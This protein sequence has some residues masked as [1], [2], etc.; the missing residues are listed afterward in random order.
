MLQRHCT[1]TQ[2]KG[3]PLTALQQRRREVCKALS[4]EGLPLAPEKTRKILSIY[5]DY[6]E[7]E[8]R[9][10][11]S[12]ANIS[13]IQEMLLEISLIVRSGNARMRLADCRSILL[14]LTGIYAEGVK[15]NGSHGNSIWGD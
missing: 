12:L 13:Q 9:V 10:E 2:T 7:R 4:D 15:R 3:E 8:L 1:Q 5:L 14:R 6:L 11:D